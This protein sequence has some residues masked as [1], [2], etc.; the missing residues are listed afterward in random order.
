VVKAVAFSGDQFPAGTRSFSIDKDD[1]QMPGTAVIWLERKKMIGYFEA[2]R[3]SDWL[4]YFCPNRVNA[5]PW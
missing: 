4:E 5:T 3:G 1:F 2:L